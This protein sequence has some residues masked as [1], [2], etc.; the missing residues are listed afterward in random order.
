MKL[1]QLDLKDMVAF[2]SSVVFLA[3]LLY[4][5]LSCRIGNRSEC[6]AA[7]FIPGHNLVGEGFDVVRLQ[8]KGAYVIDVKTYLT[9]SGLCTLCSN[10][11]QG[12]RVQ[13]LP[14]S[15]IDWRAFSR[16][17]T[18]IHSSSHTTVSSLIKA[19]CAQDSNDWKVGLNLEKYVSANLEVGG[20]RSSVYSFGSQRSSE[21]R[22]SFS[23]HRVTCRHYSFRTS[24]RPPLSSEFRKDVGKLPSHYNSSTRDQY[25]ELILI[26]GTHYIRQVHLGGRLRRVTAARTCL[27]ALNGLSSN[28]VHS[29]LF[30]GM[31]VGLGKLKPSRDYES[32]KQ[33]L[34]NQGISTTY[35]SGFHQHYTDVSGGNGWLGEFSLAHNDSTGYLTW[36]ESLKDH[37]DIV[38]YSLRPIYDLMPNKTQRAGMKAAIEQYLEDNAVKC[39]PNE[40]ACGGY[41]PNLAPNCCPIQAWRGTL[42]VTIIRGWN[43]RGDYT[44]NTESYAQMWFASHYHRTPMI[45]SNDPQWNASYN[46]GKVDTHSSLKVEAWDEDLKYDD[47]LGSCVTS[48]VQGT[49]SF[50][51]PAIE[52]GFEVQYTL[53]CD[54]HLTGDKCERYKP[55]PQ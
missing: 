5:V 12:N 26:Y 8:R 27:S 1:Q 47:C 46:L 52:G 54:P 21:D 37:P 49:H 51:C 36:L 53:T 35:N 17:S 20:T 14:A 16:C 30:L 9:D 24:A 3:I 7:T 41:T 22:H 43:L 13:K 50:T 39:S 2:L 33:V 29:C 44:G 45:R 23:I 34:Q 28:Q 18:D 15:V 19:Y 6:E 4:P 31:S 11:L 55:S 38:S 10:S 42:K 48:V 40:P 25:S 32:C